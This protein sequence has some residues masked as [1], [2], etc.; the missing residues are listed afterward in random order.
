M[1][2]YAGETS[3]SCY[4]RHLQHL[5]KYSLKARGMGRTDNEEGATFMWNHTKSVHGGI[6][7]A[8]NGAGDYQMY[9]DGSFRDPLTRQ[10]DEDVRMRVGLEELVKQRCKDRSSDRNIEL[11]NSKNE[12]FKPKSVITTF[13][14][15]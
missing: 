8:D 3:Q 1:Y 5:S 6:P 9:L 7:G 12:Y 15:W 2:L 11:M 13:S 14:Q 4:T 10:V